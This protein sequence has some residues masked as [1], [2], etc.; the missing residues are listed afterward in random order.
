MREFL[1]LLIWIFCAVGL[2]AS[3]A[4][5]SH[6][7]SG[8]VPQDSDCLLFLWNYFPN[9]DLVLEWWLHETLLSWITHCPVDGICHVSNISSASSPALGKSLL[10][11]FQSSFDPLRTAK[12]GNLVA[13]AWNTVWASGWV[14]ETL[15][16]LVLGMG[17]FYP[18]WSC[19]S[20]RLLLCDSAQNLTEPLL[21]TAQRPLSASVSFGRIF[22]LKTQVRLAREY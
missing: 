17:V 2:Q 13:T 6:M 22:C 8:F 16:D 19:V 5:L 20:A 18:L 11:S 10:N 3:S 9:V 1:L 7:A 15:G 4:S 12:T 21:I 14:W